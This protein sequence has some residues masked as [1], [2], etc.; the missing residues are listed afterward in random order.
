MT[1]VYV[2]T[3][4]CEVGFRIWGFLV[5]PCLKPRIKKWKEN[6]CINSASSVCLFFRKIKESLE[7]FPVKLNNLIHTLVQMSVTGSAKPPAPETIPQ[8]W[9]MLDAE[10]SIARATILG[11]NKKSDSVCIMLFACPHLPWSLTTLLWTYILS[12]LLYRR[13]VCA[14]GWTQ[15]HKQWAT[16]EKEHQADSY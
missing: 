2:G 13:C 14:T 8:E 5:L 15:C 11:F 1:G 12:L 3:C 7:C 6:R 9:M 4:S 16:R 10:K